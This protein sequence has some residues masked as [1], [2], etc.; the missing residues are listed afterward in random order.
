MAH[1][2]DRAVWTRAWLGPDQPVHLLAARFVHHRYV[3]HAHEEFAIGVCSSGVEAIRYRGTQWIAVPGTVVVIEPGEAHTGGPAVASG[4]AYRAAYPSP[5]L[6]AE[7]TGSQPHFRTPV[8]YDPP[9][10]AALGAVHHALSDGGDR[11]AAESRWTELLGEL[12]RRHTSA[13]APPPVPVSARRIAAAT[14]ER[15]ADR[16]VDPPALSHIAAELGVS[17]FQV[18][19]G[20]REAVG[21]PPYAWLA[22]YRVS[23]ARALLEAGLRPADVATRVGFADQAHLTR[24]FRRVVGVTPGVFRNSVQDSVGGR[25]E[26]GRSEKRAEER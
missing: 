12:V 17:R 3:P 26:T 13:A 19:R 23:R 11:L 14:K 5:R 18:V 20:F 9:L 24:W 16:L 1:D 22:Q 6:L 7:A 10:A 21:M 8:I 4:F 2:T 25:G 15:L